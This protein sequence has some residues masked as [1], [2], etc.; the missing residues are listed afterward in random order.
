[1]QFLLLSYQRKFCLNQFMR[2]LN[3][4]MFESGKSTGFTPVPGA[5]SS[6]GIPP[7]I[8]LKLMNYSLDQKKLKIYPF[9]AQV[10][11]VVQTR[12]LTAE[13]TDHYYNTDNQYSV[14]VE[15][16]QAVNFD[17]VKRINI[18]DHKEDFY[19][20]DWGY[21]FNLKD[22]ELKL[23]ESNMG[24]KY[25]NT[26]L[27]YLDI[28]NLLNRMNLYG[29]MLVFEINK[30][31]AIVTS[32]G[33]SGALFSST[34]N[35]NPTYTAN[36]FTK[37]MFNMLVNHG[38]RTEDCDTRIE[39]MQKTA[40]TI[41][42]L[43]I[44]SAEQRLFNPLYESKME[45]WGGNLYSFANKYI[46]EIN[47]FRL[48]SDNITTE[49]DAITGRI[50]DAKK[51]LDSYNASTSNENPLYEV[52]DM[53]CQVSINHLTYLAHLMVNMFYG[54]QIKTS[55]DNQDMN[56]MIRKIVASM[57]GFLYNL[58]NNMN[59]LKDSTTTARSAFDQIQ[60]A[61]YFALFVL[62]QVSEEAR[63][64]MPINSLNGVTQ[65]M[66]QVMRENESRLT[67]AVQSYSLIIKIKPDH[68]DIVDLDVLLNYM[69]QTNL[70][71]N[72]YASICQLLMICLDSP[73]LKKSVATPMTLNSV[74]GCRRFLDRASFLQ[75]NYYQGELKDSEFS[76]WL[77]T[78]NVI[79]HAFGPLRDN[80]GS[81]DS[82]L[83][84]VRV[85]MNRILSV[86][87]FQFV[88]LSGG[89]NSQPIISD[90]LRSRNEC[91]R[92]TAFVEELELT[93]TLINLLF[94]E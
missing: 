80:T 56:D 82:I 28:Y 26:V 43:N 87:G 93:A 72:C 86:L 27:H 59:Y 23:R 62:S 19:D 13:A 58:H 55:E 51:E 83:A 41:E 35:Q 81:V 77:W 66:R 40:M 84:F 63:V 47:T 85:Y 17:Q 37:N 64:I 10:T 75:M 44:T 73:A 53:L 20:E 7:T 79:I 42:S 4:H 61:S 76:N 92:S 8:Y 12:L 1:M 91:F 49:I 38:L 89:A 65:F 60:I 2:V 74:V 3:V 48:L 5:E 15:A 57:S 32:T 70:E 68:F 6:N 9:L 90:D 94:A 45:E 22:T 24:F 54:I 21:S 34:L 67:L 18:S 50:I 25:S 16:D 78:L 88:S 46:D 69:K 11:N 30:N 36:V 52:L 33:L 29:K 39:F 14:Y 31:I 71:S